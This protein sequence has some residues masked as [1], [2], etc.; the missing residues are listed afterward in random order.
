M[1]AGAHAGGNKRCDNFVRREA[2]AA[3]KG[4]AI[5]GLTFYFLP[6]TSYFRSGSPNEKSAPPVATAMYWR[7]STE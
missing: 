3:V 1:A 6:P 7:P 4:I 2:S 5:A